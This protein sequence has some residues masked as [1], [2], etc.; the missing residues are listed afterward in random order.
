MN[1]SEHP[2]YAGSS[3]SRP[4]SDKVIFSQQK[5]SHHEDYA[6]QAMPRPDTSVKPTPPSPKIK[7]N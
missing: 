2:C 1:A 5:P 7:K 3:L 4:I 6:V